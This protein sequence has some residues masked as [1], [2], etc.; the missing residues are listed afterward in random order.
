MTPPREPSFPSPQPSTSDLLAFPF[1]P[2]R[3]WRLAVLLPALLTLLTGACSVTRFQ[4]TPLAQQ[5]GFVPRTIPATTIL[6]RNGTSARLHLEDQ[7][8]YVKIRINGKGPF[9]FEIDTGAEI[10]VIRPETAQALR[11]PLRQMPVQISEPAGESFGMHNIARAAELQLG[12][13]RFQDVDMLVHALPGTR[14]GL[15]NFNF[16]NACLWTLDYPQH[17][18]FLAAMPDPQGPMVPSGFM[19][20]R[21]VNGS[22]VI[23]VAIG[24]SHFPF[25]LDS[26]MSHSLMMPGRAQ[27]HLSLT[28]APVYGATFQT[29]NYKTTTW[30]GKLNDDL[31]LQGHPVRQPIVFFNN[32]G[33]RSWLGFGIMRR[34]GVTFHPAGNQVR[35]VP[36]PNLGDDTEVLYGYG[37][38]IEPRG[39]EWEIVS[40]VPGSGAERA[41]LRAGQRVIDW[42][43][44]VFRDGSQGPLNLRVQDRD[45]SVFDAAAPW[46]QLLP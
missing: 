30:V 7:A 1:L 40:V 38:H 44:Q 3:S 18:I 24:N 2:L 25:I 10:A 5:E 33:D 34:F 37:F 11:L 16:F 9:V 6:P 41:G 45:G 13:A 39:N 36:D 31:Y 19:T 22:P 4:G 28:R 43:G 27:R 14:D 23:P 17:R 32:Q 12:E 15:L 21:L 35:F 46:E 20:Y 8:T 29:L 42:K 26:G